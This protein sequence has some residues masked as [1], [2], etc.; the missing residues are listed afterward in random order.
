MA[1]GVYAAL[2]GAVA[3]GV[4][5]DSTAQNLANASTAGYQKLRPVFHEAM[6]RA[7]PQRE[8]QDKGNRFAAASGTVIDLSPGVTRTTGRALDISLPQG[9]FL[10]VSTPRGERYTRA[11]SM[12]V[13]P[14]GAL[15]VGGQKVVDDSGNPIQ[16]DVSAAQDLAISEDGQLLQGGETLARIKLVTF[17]EPRMLGPEGGTLFTATEA[18]G[19][20]TITDGTIRIGELEESNASPVTAMTELMTTTRL[21]DAFQRAI[22]TFRDADRKIA[23]LPNS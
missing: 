11:G 23:S 21:F 3:A 17:T 14:A 22:E 4:A 19:P 7:G 6:R 13:D 10:A 2:S 15:T 8:Q 18:S 20:P 12:S 9:A 1:K 16:I 5:L